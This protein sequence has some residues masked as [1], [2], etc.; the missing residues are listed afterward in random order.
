MNT[1]A[2]ASGNRH[3]ILEI[4][5]IMKNFGYHVI[6]RH[7]AGV[8][9]DLEIKETGDTFE[10]NSRIK[11]EA[12]MK[13]TGMPAIADDSGLVTDA[14]DGAPG[15]YSARFAG[16][17]C[18]DEKNNDRLLRLLAGVPYEKRTARFVSVITLVRPG[19]APLTARG[20]CEGHILF[21]RRGNGGFGYDPLFLP[22]ESEYTF[23]EISQEEK[24]R[25]SHRARALRSLAEQLRGE[26][27]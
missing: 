24:N 21:E 9:D 20:E 22:V 5:E 18:D 26:E 12:V 7:E 11:A 4:E 23:A 14:L 10:E 8:P 1:I 19:K 16:E 13:I 3:K 17:P 15:V 25:I 27:S 6:S 2:A